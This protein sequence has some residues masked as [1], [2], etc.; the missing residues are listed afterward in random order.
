M[1]RTVDA[2]QHFWDPS[3][4]DYPWMTDALAPI[5]RR[6]APEDLRPDLIEKGV[7]LTILVQTRSSLKETFDFLSLAEETDFVGGVVGWVDLTEPDITERLI[8]LRSDRSGRWLV[9]IRHQ[10]HD[11][12]DPDWLLRPEVWRGLSAVESAGLVFDLLVRT[13]ELP[14]ALAAV[15]SFP[16]L[17]FVI[18]HLAKPPIKQGILD[19]WAERLSEFGGLT[20]VWCKLSGMVTEA[21]WSSWR[22]EQLTPYLD[23]VQAVFGPERLMFGSDWPVCL[24]AGSY[25]E[26]YEAARLALGPLTPAESSLVFGGTASEVYRLPETTA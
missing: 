16:G 23:H 2:H 17:R 14:A 20:N 11:E 8:E 21:E 12:P 5:R 6:F 10:V 19:P 25:A 26:V 3:S 4:G 7:E 24:L 9:G 18:D 22:L 1:T 15:R 13:R